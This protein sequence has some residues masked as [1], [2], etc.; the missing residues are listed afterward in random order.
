MR[1]VN[2]RRAFRQTIAVAVVLGAMF[3]A[4]AP[5]AQAQ[6]WRYDV[7]PG[8]WRPVFFRPRPVFVPPPPPPPA[9][10]VVVRPPPPPPAR[11]VMVRPPPPVVYR[12]VIVER[13]RPVFLRRTVVVH[14]P[15][16]VIHAPPVVV[17]EPPIVR[18]K[19]VYKRVPVY[20]HTP[21][22]HHRVHHYPAIHYRAKHCGCK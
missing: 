16:V 6:W 8:P 22:I 10:T 14:A 3:A 11:T 2:A 20:V 4:A 12:R 5:A 15:P 7:G 9:R 19:I 1:V 17:R 21:V 18:E 13:T